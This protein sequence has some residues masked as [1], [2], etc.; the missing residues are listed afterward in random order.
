MTTTNSNCLYN[1]N[2]TRVWSRVQ[3][4]CT[5]QDGTTDTIYIP[6]LNKT[7]TFANAAK[8]FSVLQ[9]GNV[10]QYKHNS[11]HLT[12]QQ[13]YAQIAKGCWTNR[14]KTYATQSQSYSNPNTNS[15]KRINY[16]TIT[17][18]GATSNAPIT[19]T[20]PVPPTIPPNLPLNN[21]S[22]LPPIV[23][24]PPPPDISYNTIDMPTNAPVPPEPAP[25]VIPN[26]G[27]L[28]CTT[29]ENICTGEILAQ[30]MNKYCNPTSASDVPGP[31]IEL[32]YNDNL[33]PTYYP[34]Q[35]VTQASSGGNKFPQGYKGFNSAITI[36]PPPPPPPH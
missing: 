2:P 36:T 32:C 12:K 27:N 6:V 31:I 22:V 35:T 34:R 28:I 5:Y 8:E 13:R 1:P 15:L 26:S 18:D 33:F 14:S 16:T 25:V 23:V 4:S 19:C 10:L 7:I 30:T 24:P 17:L 20:F 9:K 29:T 11:S 3:S 21:G